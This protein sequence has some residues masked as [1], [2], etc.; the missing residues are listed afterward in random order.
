M[1]ISALAREMTRY[2]NMSDVCYAFARNA[3]LE[4]PVSSQAD[5]KCP[6][7]LTDQNDSPLLRARMALGVFD[8]VLHMVAYVSIFPISS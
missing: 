8:R 7:H 2:I 4:P 5:L 3:L 6:C 1:L